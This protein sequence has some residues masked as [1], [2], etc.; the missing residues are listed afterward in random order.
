MQNR[1]PGKQSTIKV[2]IKAKEKTEG[3]KFLNR[4]S[5]SPVQDKGREKEPGGPVNMMLTIN[6]PQSRCQA[7]VI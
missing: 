7:G 1:K 5:S 3:R 4:N 2:K 6:R